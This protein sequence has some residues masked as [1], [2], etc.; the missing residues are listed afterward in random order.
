MRLISS[1]HVAHTPRP[2]S[3]D[4]AARLLPASDADWGLLRESLGQATLPKLLPTTA[5][6]TYWI[7]L[8]DPEREPLLGHLHLVGCTLG[9]NA[10]Y[11]GDAS[12][13]KT[14]HIFTDDLTDLTASQLWLLRWTVPWLL[15]E[16]PLYRAL[17]LELP[18]YWVA[19]DE[20]RTS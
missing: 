15:P 6:C 7:I 17:R 13:W 3:F 9:Q 8:K 19:F 5:D 2:V 10:W 16:H 1:G 12:V 14:I 11:D 20:W 4:E 18:E